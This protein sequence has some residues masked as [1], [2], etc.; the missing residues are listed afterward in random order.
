[1]RMTKG[2]DS[3][4]G[5]RRSTLTPIIALGAVISFVGA[6]G[7]LA[8]FTDSAATGTNSYSSRA[9]PQSADLLLAIGSA[10]EGNTI[11]CGT[12]VD[13]LETGIITETDRSPADNV[14]STF[15]CVGNAG[16]QTVNVD[17]AAIDLV[18]TD[19]ACT[20][21]EAT[22]DQTCG[23]DAEGS[24]Q[25]G[26]LSGFLEIRVT[27]SDCNAIDEWTQTQP[28]TL[29]SMTGTPVALFPLAPNEVQCLNIG[30]TYGATPDDAQ[31]TQSDTVEW[32]FSFDAATT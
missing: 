4:R 11:D 28:V 20:G 19:T 2:G 23:L 26:E 1:M 3:R 16:S 5:S 10:G 22:V 27:Y 15:L 17:L 25:E 8:V 24:A 12:Y 21:D 7:V 14:A 18:D 30:S 32:R 29:A 9:E 13:D 6:N 31:S